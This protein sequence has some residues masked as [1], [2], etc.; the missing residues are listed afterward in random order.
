MVNMFVTVFRL[1]TAPVGNETAGVIVD[2]LQCEVTYNITAGGI[3]N[4][5]LIGSRSSHGNIT[6]GLCPTVTFSMYLTS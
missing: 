5:D 2:G 1:G 3:L 4:G 6:A